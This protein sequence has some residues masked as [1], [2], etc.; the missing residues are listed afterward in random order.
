MSARVHPPAVVL[1]SI[2]KDY[3]NDWRGRWWR[4]LNGVT[5]RVARGTI[6]GLIGA[7]GAGKSTTLRV[8]AALTEPTAGRCEVMGFP[9]MTAVLEGKI[10]YLPE[11]PRFE[12]YLTGRNQLI[13]YARLAGRSERAA[14]KASD[15][16]LALVGLADAGSRP[17]SGYSK[18][19]RQRLGIAQAVLNDQEVVLL[20]EPASALDPRA[21]DELIRTIRLLREHGK[22]V[23]MSTHFLPQL[24]ELCDQVVLL[25]EGRVVFDGNAAAVAAAGGLQRIFLERTTK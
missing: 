13:A 2:V 14:Q 10:G 5:F 18:G 3:T 1:E 11:E 25:E 7:N 6:C 22:C 12:E 24:E 20:D 19:M 8:I 21:T 17:I 16:K 9:A 4:A 15:E 23:I